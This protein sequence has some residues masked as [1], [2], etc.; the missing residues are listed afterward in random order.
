[1]MKSIIVAMAAGLMLSA[2]AS[3]ASAQDKATKNNFE[4]KVRAINSLGKKSETAN[5]GFRTIS[6]ETGVSFDEVKG[7]HKKHP[8]A[9]PAGLMIACV[10]ADETKT[11]PEK[12]LQGHI[13][14]K[15]W[16]AM[17]RDHK[18]PL[19]KVNERLDHLERSMS[20][21]SKSEKTVKSR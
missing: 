11:A 15:S 8:D 1:M 3:V 17:I 6:V 10:L 2:G 20:N 12:F 4:E 9:G 21:P 18:V 19:E 14:G 7:M 5:V 13:D 16:E